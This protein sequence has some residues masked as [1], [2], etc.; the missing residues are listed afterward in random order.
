MADHILS[1]YAK[2]TDDALALVVRYLGDR[3]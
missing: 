2:A 1:R 3:S